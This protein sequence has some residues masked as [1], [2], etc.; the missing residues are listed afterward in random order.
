MPVFVKQLGYNDVAVRNVV[1]SS[2]GRIGADAAEC[3]NALAGRFKDADW[4]VRQSAVRAF[5]AIGK[6]ALPKLIELFNDADI[7]KRR[8][9]TQSLA[10][11][12]PAALPALT[13]QFA[14]GNADFR[15]RACD[16][17]AALGPWAAAAQEKLL[18]LLKDGDA[19]VRRSAARAFRRIGPPAV[20]T[21]IAAVKGQDAA[22][23]QPAAAG[24]LAGALK[25]AA[26]ETRRAAAGALA[27]MGLKAQSAAPALVEVLT[28]KDPETAR[29][30]A[31]ALLNIN[32]AAVEPL[33]EALQGDAAE[34]RKAAARVLATIGAPAIE[35]LTAALKAEKTEVR[36]LAAVAI[37]RTGAHGG[38]AAKEAATAL[39]AALRD[40]RNAGN[41]AKALSKIT[42]K[43]FGINAEQWRQWLAEQ[44]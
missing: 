15:R 9:A 41:A 23:R 24:E 19:T 32:N 11:L 1:V 14:G 39:V 10:H 27:R 25:E 3:V 4:T 18:P 33:A 37:G 38:P 30:A 40:T 31:L 20:G 6:P 13:A 44:E 8:G 29:L 17:I 12:G 22:L 28:D 2:L 36:M 7:D 21:L 34:L 26:P 5:A 42:G 16:V 35:T 43:R